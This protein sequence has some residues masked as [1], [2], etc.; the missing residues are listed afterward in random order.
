MSSNADQIQL[1]FALDDCRKGAAYKIE[2]KF[3]NSEPFETEQIKNKSDSKHI[4]FTKTLLCEYHFS[5]IQFLQVKMTRWKDRTHFITNTLLEDKKNFRLTLS[6]IVSSQN[7]IFTQKINEKIPTI[8]TITIRAE[9]PNYLQQKEN[10]KYTL[11]DYIKSGIKIE[12]IIGIDFTQGSEHGL[13]TE[14]NQYLQAVAGFRQTLYDYV[15]DFEVYGYGAKLSETN[16]IPDFFNLDFKE[17]S[18][19]HGFT[20]IEKAYKECLRKI[21]YCDNAS[22]SPLITHVKNR[23]YD[24]YKLDKYYIFFLLISNPPKR[25]DFQKCIDAFIENSYLPVS[26]III[27]IGDKEFDEIKSIFSKKHKFS[28]NDMERCRNNIYFLTMKDCNFLNDILKNKCL[29]EIPK[30]I[31]EFYVNSVTTPD[32]IKSKNMENIKNSF[33]ILESKTSIYVDNTNECAPPSLLEI[34]GQGNIINNNNENENKFNNIQSNENESNKQFNEDKKNNINVNNFDINNN[35]K[36]NENIDNFNINNIINDKKNENNNVFYEKPRYNGNTNINYNINNTNNNMNNI[37]NIN[38]LNNNNIN[39]LNNDN[40]INNNL[41]NNNIINNN[42]NNNNIINNNLNNNYI[43]DIKNLN[44]SKRDFVNQTPGK[45]EDNKDKFIYKPNPFAKDNKTYNETPIIQPPKNN[46]INIP[47]PYCQNNN[48]KNDN[49]NN[50]INEIK[51]DEKYIN[52]INN[53]TKEDKKYINNI[54]NK[55]KEDDKKICNETPRAQY[56]YSNQQKILPNPYAKNKKNNEKN[57]QEDI[58][59]NNINQNN[60][61][62]KKKEKIYCTPGSDKQE[63]YNNK[64]SNNMINPLGK[65]I[66]NNNINM[67]QIQ[68]NDKVYYNQTPNPEQD[69][70]KYVNIDNP[71]AKKKNLEE[72][73]LDEK[74]YYNA[75]PGDAEHQ[76]INSNISYQS[77]PFKKM[78]SSNKVGHKEEEIDIRKTNTI[79]V[80]TC[81]KM[82]NQFKQSIEMIKKKSSM[83]NNST[84]E[85]NSSVNMNQIIK[86]N[87]KK[88]NDYNRVE[89]YSI[90]N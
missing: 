1:S 60:V 13:D 18:K 17:N 11:F 56:Q 54:N 76:K 77:N 2:I 32:D 9:N 64:N 8:E 37:N 38:N 89:D 71:F 63:I 24:D 23:I 15:R 42:L 49:I 67:N 43:N 68:K 72:K 90:D 12:S 59:D 20:N 84:K 16:E 10:K 57:I 44:K 5:K 41:N 48:I 80:S 81:N 26:M 3:D 55:I 46:Y 88:S 52:N 22:L 79:N 4:E 58:K 87:L 61:I 47:N 53:E 75:T 29:K 27:G 62:I 7:S 35:H 78:L 45:E 28:S 65:Q 74:K 19:L 30:Q 33:R 40:I 82:G 51:E 86:D 85:S 70:K 21:N 31:P 36:N 6:T 14:K 50:R 39:N 73:Q 34:S 66:Q 83:N 25:E 69:N